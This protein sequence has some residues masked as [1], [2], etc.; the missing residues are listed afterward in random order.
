MRRVILMVTDSV[1][2]G[3]LPDAASYGDMGANTFAH[4]A[5]NTPGFAVPNLKKMGFGNIEG[6][7]EGALRKGYYYRPLGNCRN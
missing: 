5:A 7:L 3:A 4:A 6:V 1:G 2:V